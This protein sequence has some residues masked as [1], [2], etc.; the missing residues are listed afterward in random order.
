[1]GF[2]QLADSAGIHGVE[3][4]APLV[5]KIPRNLDSVVVMSYAFAARVK[6]ERISIP[7]HVLWFPV[8]PTGSTIVV[9]AVRLPQ[10]SVAIRLM[11]SKPTGT[12]LEY[13]TISTHLF[14][15]IT[16][17]DSLSLRNPDTVTIS[18]YWTQ[19][20]S[21][22]RKIIQAAIQTISRRT[23]HLLKI[24]YTS[25][26]SAIS[27]DTNFL[28]WLSHEP[29]PTTKFI[30]FGYSNC[31]AQHLPLL[32]SRQSLANFCES[33]G[34][35]W[36]FSKRLSEENVLQESF[37]YSL[38]DILLPKNSHKD[39]SLL[40][41]RVLAVHSNFT[42]SEGETPASLQDEKA[43]SSEPVLAILLFIT[44]IVERLVAYR[45]N[46]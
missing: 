8:E 32:S 14:D 7:K 3:N 39:A 10:D 15:R 22:D 43:A 40:D 5:Q 11:A 21:Y 17:A 13:S 9:D 42:N 45:R 41:R 2:P 27:P 44:L 12:T 26:V 6:G 20:F 37:M 23:P 25:T 29:M 1:E 38:G 4:Y 36:V 33:S 18:V 19:D 16:K 46:Q 24:N 31:N 34:F 28:F 35:D 30:T